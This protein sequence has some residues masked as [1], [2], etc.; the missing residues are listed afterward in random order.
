MTGITPFYKDQAVNLFHMDCVEGLRLLEEEK[1][2]G[3]VTSPPYG[4][5]KD[6]E[7]TQSF[8]EYLKL[9][10]D[11]THEAYRV[12]RQ[13]GYMVINYADYYSFDGPNSWVQPM[14]YLYH[15]IAERSGW[16]HMCTR[17]WKKDFA[18]LVDPYSIATTLPK[19][20][21][22][23]IST[24]RKPSEDRVKEV[25]REQDLHPRQIWDTSGYKQSTSTLKNHKAAYP[26]VLMQFVFKVY[27]EPGQT[28]IDP[29]CGSG[30]TPFVA[31]KMGIKCV[32]FEKDLSSC[33]LSAKRLQQMV[34][35]IDEVFGEPRQITIDEVVEEPIIVPPDF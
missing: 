20:E 33:E 21:C 16:Q 25:V 22:E 12:I 14:E 1:Y 8:G 28:W 13:G 35:D 11:F 23:H 30:T 6:Y 19:L 18:S 9:L 32:A 7:K 24:F 10:A 15:L 27:A 26:E 34:F 3:L 31:K 4:V 29:F 2:D 17:V 5:G